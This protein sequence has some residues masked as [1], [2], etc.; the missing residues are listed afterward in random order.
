MHRQLI[1]HSS[2]L[3]QPLA[4][5]TQKYLVDHRPLQDGRDDL[6]LASATI[7]ALLHVDVEHALEQ[8]CPADAL[9]P[10]FGDLALGGGCGNAAGPFPS[11]W[12]ATSIVATWRV[13]TAVSRPSPATA[14]GRYA[15]VPVMNS[16]AMTPAGGP[17]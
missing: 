9:R 2:G 4:H 10:D 16:S 3:F 5:L 7:W 1:G 14:Y 11:P 13:G 12:V 6:E 15:Q 17:W 8:S